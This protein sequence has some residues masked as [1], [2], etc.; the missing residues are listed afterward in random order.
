MYKERLKRA[1]YKL[2]KPREILL[3]YLSKN[4]HPKSAGDI[5]KGIKKKLD[6]VTVYRILEV[7]EDVGVVFKEHNDTESLYYLAEEQHHH[8]I[9]R[10]CGRSECVPC[11]HMFNSIKNF[12]NIK[13]QLTLT[14]LCNKCNN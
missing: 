7:F 6:K 11:Q 3:D 2:T 9:C 13:H 1:G 14:G 5:Y 10:K 4:D 8:I 12:K